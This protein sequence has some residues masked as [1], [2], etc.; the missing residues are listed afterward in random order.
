MCCISIIRKLV[1]V[2]R[3]QMETSTLR[4]HDLC[5][6]SE[7]KIALPMLVLVLLLSF[8]IFNDINCNHADSWLNLSDYAHR[9]DV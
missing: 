5:F 6:F 9:V 1:R 7:M 4:D 3:L 2:S 8:Y